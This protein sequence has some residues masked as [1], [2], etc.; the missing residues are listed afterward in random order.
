[1]AG[2]RLF[3]LTLQEYH[4]QSAL[5]QALAGF[6]GGDRRIAEYLVEDVLSAQPA[7]LQDFLLHTSIL[8]RLCA[9]L[10][11][12]LLEIEN[13]E[14]KIE[15]TAGEL[16][17]FQFSILN[18][19]FTLEY[20]ERANLF[21]VPLDGQRH[22]YRYH[23]LFAEAMR[24]QARRRFGQAG[25]RALYGR[26][27]RWYEQQGQLADAVEAALNAH[28]FAAAAALIARILDSPQRTNELHTLRRWIELLPEHV[29]N[30]HPSLCLAYAV[31][32]LFT[33]NR[34]A[35]TTAALLQPP[36]LVAER[37]WRATDDRL[38]LGATL[39]FRAMVGWWQGELPQ[40]FADARAALELL[41]EHD[42]EWRGPCL[43]QVAYETLLAG[44]VDAAHGLVL[45]ARACCD[46]VL[47]IHASLAATFLLGDICR[48]QGELRH[49]GQLYQAV[50]EASCK[51]EMGEPL[52]D[53][54]G[55]LLGL[56]SLDYE[57][58][59]LA[60]AE[61]CAT[62]TLALGRKLCAD[63]LLV[64]ATLLLARVLHAGGETVRA[65]LLLDALLAPTQR[66]QPWQQREALAAQAGWRWREATW[67]PCSAGHPHTRAVARKFRPFSKSRKRCSSPVC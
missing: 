61:Q 37:H 41:P 3:A 15:K 46:A 34:R 57:H 6:S 33:E 51:L 45:E 31:A 7:P 4:T 38:M 47:N 43:L 27:S 59:D 67:L 54:A 21:L 50:F 35:P 22:W 18:S 32:L 2:L 10:C 17:H 64:P 55:A 36:L 29:R 42:Q 66:R 40:A 9:D 58:N 62:E 30:E 63:E 11:D 16:D 56:G 12:S 60:T 49:A 65:Q 13:A 52:D 53:R 26:A 5:E 25:L 8:D 23:A 1:V 24:D 20:L 28:E 48:Q 44:Q 19:Q 14:L 39:T